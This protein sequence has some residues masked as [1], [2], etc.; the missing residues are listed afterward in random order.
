MVGVFA[1]GEDPVFG[2][3]HNTAAFGLN[4]PNGGDP[5][6]IVGLANYCAFQAEICARPDPKAR[7]AMRWPGPAELWN[8]P[9]FGNG[10]GEAFDI[11]STGQSVGWGV[12][13]NPCKARALL[14]EL[15]AQGDPTDLH[16]NLLPV[17]DETE[18]HAINS[19]AM[20]VGTNTVA[21]EALLWVEEASGWQVF[22]LNEIELSNAVAC[23]WEQLIEANDINDND[24]IVGVGDADPGGSVH[25]RAFLLTPIGDCPADV[26]G[27]GE[28]DIEDY[29]LIIATWGD[30]QTGKI[31]AADINADCVV[32]V[33][34]FLKWR[35][36]LGPCEGES[37]QIEQGGEDV[38][39]AVFFEVLQ[40]LGFADLKAYQDWVVEADGAE[41]LV[42]TE[43]LS[44]L[45]WGH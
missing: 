45:V 29:L 44:T 27:D 22:D 15:G 19:D 2:D 20:I 36:R 7:D 26:N 24:W 32:N 10:I 35:A 38:S 5:V 18:A 3:N 9:A 42:S 13:E 21:D 34:D 17:G 39:D 43:I 14:W 28:V 8:P 12:N 37:G 33:Q 4:T 6:R 25:F 16:V 11:N 40:S 30:C 31:C 41:V 23:G 1:A